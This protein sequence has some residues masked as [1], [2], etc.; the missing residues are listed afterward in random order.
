MA[1]LGALYTVLTVVTIPIMG[2]P[3][4]QS[5]APPCAVQLQIQETR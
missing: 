2:D 3:I 1:F 4:L 5:T